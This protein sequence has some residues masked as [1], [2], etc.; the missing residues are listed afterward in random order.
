MPVIVGGTNYYI[1]SILWDVLV[2]KVPEQSSDNDNSASDSE[3]SP[4]KKLRIDKTLIDETKSTSI[5]HLLETVQNIAS[6]R[7]QSDVSDLKTLCAAV[8]S[9][10]FNFINDDLTIL[11]V[12]LHDVLKRVDPKMADRLH[13]NNRRKIIR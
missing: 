1:E 2:D 5:K 10:K 4:A 7:D 9:D 8:R 12:E 3:E 11:S 6:E 13:P